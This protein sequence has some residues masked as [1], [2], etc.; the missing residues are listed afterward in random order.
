MSI[1]C[2]GTLCSSFL[3][4]SYDHSW[5]GYAPYGKQAIKN[6]LLQ[7][8]NSINFSWHVLLQTAYLY[9]ILLRFH[10]TELCNIVEID[11]S[12]IRKLIDVSKPRSF[13]TR[14]FPLHRVIADPIWQQQPISTRT[15]KNRPATMWAVDSLQSEIEN[16]RETPTTGSIH[17]EHSGTCSVSTSQPPNSTRSRGP[18]T[19]VT[20]DGISLSQRSNGTQYISQ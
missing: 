14:A 8:L 5:G 3:I 10:E 6:K 17:T 7:Y 2:S 4:F 19:K 16:G 11:L 12:R 18:A 20:T 13:A 15:V 1:T 9:I